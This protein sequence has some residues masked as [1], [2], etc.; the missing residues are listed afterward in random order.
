MLILLPIILDRRLS[1]VSTGHRFPFRI[2]LGMPTSFEHCSLF[3]MRHHA[4]GVG[5]DNMFGGSCLFTLLR[6]M[7]YKIDVW[8]GRS[9]LVADIIFSR[10]SVAGNLL[11]VMIL[12]L[13]MVQPLI[14]I[15]LH[16]MAYI[17]P[18]C[19]WTTPPRS[20]KISK[21]QWNE[22]RH[23]AEESRTAKRLCSDVIWGRM[24]AS[25]AQ[26]YAY[27]AIQDGSGRPQI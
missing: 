6:N 13:I 4:V 21:R 24:A 23:G 8:F 14:L 11:P 22:L 1:L 9:Y 17:M 25:T 19:Q 16:I 5:D 27:D 3:T 20:K 10:S 2:R 18:P 7:S 26:K 12:P 15:H